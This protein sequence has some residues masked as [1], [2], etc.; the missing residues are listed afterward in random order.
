[1]LH[2][3]YI[4]IFQAKNDP[5]LA[6]CHLTISPFFLSKNPFRTG[7][8]MPKLWENMRR[9]HLGI[10]IKMKA[11]VV[12]HMNKRRVLRAAICGDVVVKS[13]FRMGQQNRVSW[14]KSGTQCFSCSF[15]FLPGTDGHRLAPYSKQDPDLGP[16]PLQSHGPV[17]KQRICRV[18]RHNVMRL[19]WFGSDFFTGTIICGRKNCHQNTY[20]KPFWTLCAPKMMKSFKLE[21]FERS[22]RFWGFNH[23]QTST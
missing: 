11:K 1:M 19:V 15:E 3:L 10:A 2:H 21:E 16:K 5:F 4:C 18:L 9:F 17:E 14:W 8:G 22:E 12:L 20:L 6:S 13:Q 23:L 7:D